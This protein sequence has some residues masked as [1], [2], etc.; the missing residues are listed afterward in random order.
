[1]ARR[2]P[3]NADFDATVLEAVLPRHVWAGHMRYR[4]FKPL[5][6]GGKAEVFRCTD[7][8]L[9]RDVA[10]KI[11]HKHLCD[12][13]IEQQLL[14]REARVMAALRHP[15][16]PSVHDLGRDPDGRPYFAMS[17]KPGPTLY[18]VLNGLRSGDEE[19]V[20]TYDLERLLGVLVHVAGALQYAHGMN[21]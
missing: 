18:D 20:R 4:N 21:V 11:L 2:T 10:L 14:V 16:I 3:L 7:G 13:P 5:A 6:A 15:S 19:I 17:L 9:G 8:L 1:M 12:C